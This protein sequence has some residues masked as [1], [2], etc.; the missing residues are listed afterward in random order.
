MTTLSDSFCYK[1][2]QVDFNSALLT[3]KLVDLLGSI[4]ESANI[5]TLIQ[6]AEESDTSEK[7]AILSFIRSFRTESDK[8]ILDLA[9]F[10]IA[11]LSKI[12]GIGKIGLKFLYELYAA[13]ATFNSGV[14]SP[15]K[16]SILN[17]DT[18][19]SK[20]KEF[21][22]FKVDGITYLKVLGDIIPFT[23]IVEIDDIQCGNNTLLF[24]I[25]YISRCKFKTVDDI[26][27]NIGDHITTVVDTDYLTKGEVIKLIE[28][29]NSY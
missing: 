29:F 15:S 11:E 27:V 10:S 22:I 6:I 18:F 26:V 1:E 21:C 3:N 13:Q 16:K 7:R 14:V 25:S 28:L 20:T 19:V 23:S 2:R 12:D 5:R 9:N 8:T 17:Y 4:Q 24:E